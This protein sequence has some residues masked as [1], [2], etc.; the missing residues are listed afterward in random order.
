M[1]TALLL[2]SQRMG[3]RRHRLPQHAKYRQSSVGFV[4]VVTDTNAFKDGSTVYFSIVFVRDL[5]GAAKNVA[6]TRLPI[7]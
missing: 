1:A 2:R 7:V 4:P 5:D 3:R 6:Y